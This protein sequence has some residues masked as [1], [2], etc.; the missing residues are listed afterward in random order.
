M[1]TRIRKPEISDGGNILIFD[2]RVALKE[3]ADVIE[4][5]AR[6]VLK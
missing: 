3:V 1:R 6:A 5:A 4:S 2:K